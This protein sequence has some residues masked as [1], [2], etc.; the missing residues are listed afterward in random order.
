MCFVCT[1]FSTDSQFNRRFIFKDL[2]ARSDDHEL[3]YS[4]FK[5][6]LFLDPGQNADYGDLKEFFADSFS[7][8]DA[9]TPDLG[10]YH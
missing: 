7:G 9:N 6:L 8:D 10:I 2:C 1:F 3:F 5:Y 4:Y